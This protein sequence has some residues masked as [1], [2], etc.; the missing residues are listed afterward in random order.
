MVGRLPLG[1]DDR[2]FA[3]LDNAV[4]RAKPGVD[5]RAHELDVRPLIAVV[6]DVFGDLAE[7]DAFRSDDAE[8]LAHKWRVEM[9]KLIPVLG[10]RLDDSS[11]PRVEIL[12]PAW[13]LT[14]AQNF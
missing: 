10:G 9:R 1:V 14:P 4:T 12:R 8:R 11:E 6:V 5:R 2:P 3:D 7:K 13:V